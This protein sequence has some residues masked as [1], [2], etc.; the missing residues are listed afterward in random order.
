M[1]WLSRQIQW[2]SLL[3]QVFLQLRVFKFVWKQGV[4]SSTFMMTCPIEWLKRHWI[5]LVQQECCWIQCHS[6]WG[7]LA[8]GCYELV[9]KMSLSTEMM[10]QAKLNFLHY[11][12]TMQ[13]FSKG[14]LYIQAIRCFH[15]SQNR[16]LCGHEENQ[17]NQT[18]SSTVQWSATVDRALSVSLSLCHRCKTQNSK[19]LA[20]IN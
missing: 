11:W 3:T 4:S 18:R 8:W 7:L 17:K 16:N 19:T 9:K 6:S 13:L 5:F 10:N 15:L 1:I 2:L 14:I 12:W 20:L